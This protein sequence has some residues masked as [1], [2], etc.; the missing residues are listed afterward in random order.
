MCESK[1]GKKSTFIVHLILI[2]LE[3]IFFLF[4]FVSA[5]ATTKKNNAHTGPDGY[6][7]AH[8]KM[9]ELIVIYTIR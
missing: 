8:G 7:Y 2:I 6:K 5:A 9:E 3:I 4:S 1:R